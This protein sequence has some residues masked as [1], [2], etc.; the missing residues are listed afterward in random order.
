MTKKRD[1]MTAADVNGIWA[2]VPTPAK[3]GA[4]RWDAD[5]T[6]DVDETAR[7]VEGLI[8]AGVDAILTMGTLG[9]CAT[10]T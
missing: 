6:V 8:D 4:E 1:R 9:E 10:L 2:I 5:D 3:P 7:V